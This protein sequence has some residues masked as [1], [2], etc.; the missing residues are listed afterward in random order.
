MAGSICLVATFIDSSSTQHW[1]SPLNTIDTQVCHESSDSSWQSTPWP[2]HLTD[3][4]FDIEIVQNYELFSIYINNFRLW[5]HFITYLT[6]NCE[7]AISKSRHFI[8]LLTLR[9]LSFLSLRVS[10]TVFAFCFSSAFPLCS[11]L[12]HW[13]LNSWSKRS[14][15]SLC[16]LF[17]ESL[18][19][20]FS[21]QPTITLNEPNVI[22]IDLHIHK[23]NTHARTHT[24]CLPVL[25]WNIHAFTSLPSSF[26]S[27]NAN[28]LRVY[29]G[30]IRQSIILLWD[31]HTNKCGSCQLLGHHIGICHL[32]TYIHC[33]CF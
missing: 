22:V 16:F 5:I 20:F 33:T 6:C 26:A 1:R 19:L 18:A 30:V 10:S 23:Y 7:S 21:S 15:I 4:T 14:S 11:F 12:F 3:A 8:C 17:R 32:L 29:A 27:L 2:F 24:H 13:M 9:I 31:T 25:C 28:R